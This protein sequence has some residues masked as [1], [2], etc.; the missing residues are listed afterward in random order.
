MLGLDIDLLIP[1]G[2]QREAPEDYELWPQHARAWR[3]FVGC[4]TQW[5]LAV[6][7]KTYLVGLD[8][9]GVDVIRRAHGISDADWPEVLEQLQVLEREAK[10]VRNA[11]LARD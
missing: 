11:A 8:M 5:R 4:E 7:M 9:P 10:A 6:G 2:E 1:P 3:L